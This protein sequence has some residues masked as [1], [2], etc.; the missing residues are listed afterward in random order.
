MT[1]QE[2]LGV[3]LRPPR[4]GHSARL[5]HSGWRTSPAH[6]RR[7]GHRLSSA[8]NVGSDL[9]PVKGVGRRAAWLL[10]V[11]DTQDGRNVDRSAYISDRRFGVLARSVICVGEESTARPSVGSRAGTGRVRGEFPSCQ[12][13]ARLRTNSVFSDNSNRHAS[14]GFT[15]PQPAT[16]SMAVHSLSICGAR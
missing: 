5:R 3:I 14:R 13:A 9:G 12:Q 15:A 1:L 10:H 11:C 7:L 16:T 2:S 4:T 6:A 8:R